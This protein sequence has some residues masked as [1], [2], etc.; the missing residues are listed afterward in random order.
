MLMH[1]CIYIYSVYV[2]MY[3]RTYV[4]TYVCMYHVGIEIWVWIKTLVPL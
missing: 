4:R 2:C 1:M 3:V